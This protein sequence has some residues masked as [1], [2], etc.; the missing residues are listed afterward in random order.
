MSRCVWL[1]FSMRE[2]DGGGGTN[3]GVRL[4]KRGAPA[5]S[6]LGERRGVELVEE[7]PPVDSLQSRNP[8]ERKLLERG[9]VVADLRCRFISFDLAQRAN[10][11]PLA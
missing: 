6:S 11:E 2:G 9:V 8:L 1:G 5:S 4:A 10:V 7:V 3:L